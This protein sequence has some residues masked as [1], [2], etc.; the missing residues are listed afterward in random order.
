MSTTT[1]PEQH[2]W[3]AAL[4]FAALAFGSAALGALTMRGEGRPGGMWFRQLRKPAFQPPDRVFAP[5]WT[6]LYATIAYAGWKVWR[7]EPSRARTRALALWGTQ[8]G[9]NAV[10][11]PLFFGARRPAFALADVVALDAAAI[12]FAA[13]AREVAPAAARA[14]VP[15]LGWIGFATV[16]NAAIVVKNRHGR[17]RP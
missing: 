7:T 15:Y 5:V 10:W 3:L 12:G 6:V 1:A 11:T 4:G 2:S 8:L 16:L 17:A 14:V 13:A 9:L